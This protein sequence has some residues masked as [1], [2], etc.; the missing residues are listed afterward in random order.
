M[1]KRTGTSPD[2]AE[3]VQ[4]GTVAAAF[5][6]REPGPVQ[7]GVLEAAADA[8][9]ITTADQAAL[10]LAIRLAHDIDSTDDAQQIASLSRTLLAVLAAIGLTVAG[11]VSTDTK[12]PS[13]ENPLDALR[14]RAAGRLSDAPSADAATVRSISRG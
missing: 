4:V 5:L 6:G 8:D 14:A 3:P 13:Q 9:W 10:R 7:Q 12:P 1:P 2:A 11:R